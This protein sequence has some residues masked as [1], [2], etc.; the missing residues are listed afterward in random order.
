[1][2]RNH[3]HRKKQNLPMQSVDSVDFLQQLAIKPL[4][5]S[6]VNSINFNTLGPKRFWYFKEY[7]NHL[8]TNH[9]T[10][11]ISF[12][13]LSFAAFYINPALFFTGL[14]VVKDNYNNPIFKTVCSFHIAQKVMNNFKLW[15]TKKLVLNPTALHQDMLNKLSN[16]SI[17]VAENSAHL[18]IS[19]LSCVM[20][21][22]S[23][24]KHL[25][26]KD[27]NTN[28][29]Q[30]LSSAAIAWVYSGCIYKYHKKCFLGRVKT[31]KASSVNEAN[32]YQ[33][34]REII[35]NGG[36][37]QLH[38][39][40]DLIENKYR[41]EEDKRRDNAKFAMLFALTESIEYILKPMFAKN[42]CLALSISTLVSIAASNTIALG[43]YFDPK[44]Y[45]G[46]AKLDKISEPKRTK[47]GL[48]E[49]LVP[50]FLQK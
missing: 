19:L 31:T 41:I 5:E 4:P 18:L 45:I 6:P 17:Y 22:T 10:A 3:N 34:S 40:S 26:Y 32:I 36:T 14:S 27:E 12:S 35:Y 44:G 1:M 13:T 2:V 30:L 15:L 50:S 39:P 9:I 37:P 24:F 23:L 38:N 47:S 16:Y 42:H 46:L 29:G 25:I 43:Y 21:H 49:K 20:Q 11:I 33:A 8:A 48:L 28:L 7:I